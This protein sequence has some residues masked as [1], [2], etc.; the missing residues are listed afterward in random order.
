VRPKFADAIE[1]KLRKW[2]E[3]T[4]RLGEIVKAPPGAKEGSVRLENLAG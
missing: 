2:G 3:T 4:F 1:E